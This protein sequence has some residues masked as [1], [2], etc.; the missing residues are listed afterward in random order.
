MLSAKWRPFRPGEDKLRMLNLVP[1]HSPM[2]KRN[3]SSK[4]EN[5]SCLDKW[6]DIVLH[7]SV[8][9]KRLTKLGSYSIWSLSLQDSRRLDLKLDHANQCSNTMKHGNQAE[10][11]SLSASFNQAAHNLFN[12]HREIACSLTKRW[13]LNYQMWCQTVIASLGAGDARLCCAPQSTMDHLGP[14][15][16]TWFNLN[17]SMD[18]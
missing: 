12:F 6:S 14:L 16:L 9:I 3:I 7:H 17:P 11:P 18:K 2:K 13:N 10:Q 5:V 4:H 8:K 1:V 15:L